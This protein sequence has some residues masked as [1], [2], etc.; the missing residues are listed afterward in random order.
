MWN[1]L[2]LIRLVEP[3]RI[4][5]VQ[6][7]VKRFS[8]KYHFNYVADNYKTTASHSTTNS[9]IH[10]ITATVASYFRI[11]N[12]SLN[13]TYLHKLLNISMRAWVSKVGPQSWPRL[14]TRYF[15]VGLFFVFCSFLIQF[16]L[17]L[18]LTI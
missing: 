11:S 15:L 17:L 13:I 4:N 5:D 16:S 6:G 12:Y 8:Y 18:L 7:T 1:V 14:S 9:I 2:N 10:I 3:E